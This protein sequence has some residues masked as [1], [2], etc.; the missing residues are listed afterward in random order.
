MCG[1]E[2]IFLFN[3]QKEWEKTLSRSAVDLADTWNVFIQS[4]FPVESG[5]LLF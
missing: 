4:S 1:W 5:R 2:N 3:V